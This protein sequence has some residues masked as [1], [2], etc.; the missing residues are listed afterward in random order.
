MVCLIAASQGSL[1]M[2][3][4][5]LGIP[6]LFM[7]IGK[8]DLI[9][10]TAFALWWSRLII[11][12]VPLALNLSQLMVGLY[13]GSTVLR[14][15]VG[16][17]GFRLTAS[18]V[19]ALLF[20]AVLF[21]TIAVRG[22]GLRAL[23]GGEEGGARYIH[24][25]LALG[26]FFVSDW[27]RLS[28]PQWRWAIIGMVLLAIVPTLAQGL[29]VLS[30]G[31]VYQQFAFV[32]YSHALRV[33]ALSRES[34]AGTQWAIV[35]SLGK[36]MFVPFIL[37]PFKGAYRKRY[38]VFIAV[39][40]FVSALS[41]YRTGFIGVILFLGIYFFFKMRSK[42]VFILGGAAMALI[43]AA[44]LA[45]FA[46]HLP[47]GV[48]RVLSI[49][50][51]A[52]ISYEARYSAQGTV[53]WR[54]MLWREGLRHIPEYLWIG[55]GFSYDAYAGSMVEAVRGYR[56]QHE[57]IMW[58]I[59]Q[60]D[61]HQGMISTLVTVGLFGTLSFFGILFFE[62]RRHYRLMR[63]PWSDPVLKRYHLL[64]FSL[65]C[66]DIIVYV[67]AGQAH[68]NMPALLFLM[69]LLSGLAHHQPEPEEEPAPAGGDAP[70]E[71][72]PERL[73]LPGTT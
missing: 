59:A 64:F 40:L 51:G 37:W 7:A 54:L 35:G 13:L 68:V 39:G 45:A 46:S 31:A 48:Q 4:V 42:L 71:A 8:P 3:Y 66:R 28:P 69:A 72:L 27:V 33:T 22:F 17:Q 1:P 50:P 62:F 15:T 63:Q 2:L 34:A 26:L 73:G 47:F 52:D 32:G 19:F 65:M 11:P 58:A 53:D 21:V 10:L 23:G 30:G 61:Y 38:L 5:G 56:T 9:L 70:E 43:A 44:L 55:Q 14:I 67:L 60:A 18:K 36:L 16:Q 25:A 29:Y 24:M 12:G 41:G 6:Y 57:Q 49:V 20:L